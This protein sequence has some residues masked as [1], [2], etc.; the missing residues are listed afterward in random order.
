MAVSDAGCGCGEAGVLIAVSDA[1]C[2]LE[3]GGLSWQ[4]H[5]LVVGGI[6]GL[7]HGSLRCWLWMGEVG[8]LMVV[9]DTG[10]GWERRG[11]HGR[12]WV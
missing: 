5:T 9:P 8:V 11:S 3:G 10:C 4:S 12:R 6:V 1:G 2:G 7:T